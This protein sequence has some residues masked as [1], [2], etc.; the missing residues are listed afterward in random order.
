MN[1]EENVPP[2]AP[3]SPETVPPESTFTPET[4]GASAEQAAAAT[5]VQAKAFIMGEEEKGFSKIKKFLPVIFVLLVL[6]I[7]AFGIFKF[8]LPK[9]TKPQ[10]ITL[11]YWG[12]W[13]PE[14][15]MF[16]LISDYQKAHPNIKINYVFQSP[17][18]Y[19]ERLASA[20][21][22]GKGPDI[23]RF[24]NTWV[25]MLK[26]DLAPI[27]AKI[28]DAAA[29]EANYYPVARQDLRMGTSYIG[30]PL[31]IDGLGLFVNEEIFKTAGKNY[32]STW[33]E[34]RKTAT[35]LTTKDANGKIQISGV[36]LGR[37]EN[38]DHWSDIL[39]LMML[40]NGADPSKPQGSLA[41]DALTYFTLFSKVDRVW[42]ESLPNSTQAFAGG[43]L[44]MYF[45]PSWEV[46]EI[47][48]ANPNLKFSVLP[49][50]QL[51][52]TNITWAT[53]WVEGVS[54]KSQYQ[55]E[56]FEFLK[57]LSQKET[58]QKLYQAES[59]IRL[60]G[61]PYSRMDM[62]DLIKGDTY[63]GAFV[64][65][66]LAARSWYLC[67]RTFDNGIND[68]MIKY[69]EDAVNSVNFG[70]TAKEALETTA[71]GVAQILS[72]YGISA[73]VVR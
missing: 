42:D 3:Q 36:A 64:K 46:F 29:F 70:K 14:N 38:V 51:E 71:S 9:V 30:I 2:E 31:E 69:F 18:D 6:L 34:L 15:A 55:E 54:K 13:E 45:G 73:S 39:G 63:A 7:G 4:P 19:R 72:Q 40:Q 41:E 49:V 43:K 57:Y 56:S 5:A 35:E 17:R 67:S 50:P 60:F 1:E 48:K 28:M 66:A 61:E 24:H 11:T 10:E 16:R 33:D 44:A 8:F 37:T 22:S 53:Y 32:P 62:A 52:G 25:P 47:K 12:L 58:M 23:F 59:Q 27:P 21:A 65:Q 68:K 20:L 26:N